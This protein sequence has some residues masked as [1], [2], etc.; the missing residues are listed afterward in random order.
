MAEAAPPMPEG[1]STTMEDGITWY[2]T[3][4]PI[5]SKAKDVDDLHIHL[6][7]NNLTKFNMRSAEKNTTQYDTF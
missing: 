2:V 3:V 7:K 4:T 5:D 6:V 1:D